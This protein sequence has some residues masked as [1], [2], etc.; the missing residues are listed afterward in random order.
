A[1]YCTRD[2]FAGRKSFGTDSACCSGSA[3]CG[4]AAAADGDGESESWR[5]AQQDSDETLRFVRRRRRPGRRQQNQSSESTN[6]KRE[7][8]LSRSVYPRATSFQMTT[9]GYQL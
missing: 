4:N 6:Q 3:Y 1:K 2:A 9:R 7:S 5:H 8:D